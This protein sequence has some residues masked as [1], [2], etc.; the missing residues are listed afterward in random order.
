MKKI[1]KTLG[2]VLFISLF[3]FSCSKDNTPQVGVAAGQIKSSV[4]T[5]NYNFTIKSVSKNVSGDTITIKIYGT[6]DSTKEIYILFSKVIDLKVQKYEC[7]YTFSTGTSITVTYIVNNDQ[8]ICDGISGKGSINVVSYN[9]NAITGSFDISA[10]DL[11]DTTKVV[12]LNGDF[13][14]VFD[15]NSLIKDIDVPQGKM[16]A[17]VNSSFTFF[18]VMAAKVSFNGVDTTISVTGTFDNESIVLQFVNLNPTSGQ[19]FNISL[20]SLIN[21]SYIMG[22]YAQDT[23]KPFVADGQNGTTG[24]FTIV[25]IS[26]TYIQGTFQFSGKQVGNLNNVT[27]I[28]EGKYNAKIY[29]NYQK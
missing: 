27:N 17:R 25:K 24:M 7:S 29:Q 13:N 12:K 26:D 23:L 3:I 28:T 9:S 1:L 15:L 11:L 19:A 21:N 6:A 10:V 20:A 2:G 5:A 22:S 14:A 8:Y 18:D 16:Q 4:D